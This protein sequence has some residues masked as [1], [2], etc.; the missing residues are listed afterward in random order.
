MKLFLF[1]V[2]LIGDLG[3]SVYAQSW[4]D[5]AGGTTNP[6]SGPTYGFEE[7]GGKLYVV[8]A[9]T[10]AGGLSTKTLASWNGSAW[11][12]V[13]G[14]S[15]GL[16]IASSLTSFKDELVVYGSFSEVIGVPNTNNMARWNGSSWYSIG[17]SSG[18]SGSVY[19][20]VS[21]KGNLYVGGS[22]W[23]I[24]GIGVQKIA[25]WNDTVWSEVGNGLS[26]GFNEARTM[27]VYQDELY[28]GGDFTAASG[29]P[30]NYIA[31]W[32]G[33]AWDSVAGGLNGPV[34]SMFV[35]SINDVL[36]V[37]GGFTEASGV[38]VSYIASWDGSNW[39]AVGIPPAC[40][41]ALM[42][43]EN[44]LYMGGAS[45]TG[46]STDT[47]IA[48]WDGTAWQPVLGPNNTIES[49]GVYNGEL[50]VGGYFDKVNSLQVNYVARF[51]NNVAIAELNI[52]VHPMLGNC[53]PNPAQNKAVIP[54]SIR[55]ETVGVIHLYGIKGELIDSYDITSSK[56][57]L[58]ISLEDLAEGAY[59]YTLEIDDQVKD[60]RRMVIVR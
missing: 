3:Y 50:Y 27:A 56:D 60:R 17:S 32:N 38:A 10:E 8:G 22:L 35:D 43:Y 54:Y 21:Y 57:E 31:R 19:D 48:K 55:P 20:M 39:S 9:F 29:V 47:V 16:G 13:P 51:S 25:M 34:G 5:L 37:S 59:L 2:F 28:V 4:K 15:I 36:Y 7:M 24:G 41:G 26:G 30:A 42:M 46:S 6:G 14:W 45:N 58:E 23:N 11:D 33:I 53:I 1:L 44:E 12:S 18:I 40:C 49:F 52:D